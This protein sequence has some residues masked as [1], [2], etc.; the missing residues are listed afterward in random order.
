[1][2]RSRLAALGLTATLA[3]AAGASP[4]LAKTP[5]PRPSVSDI[6]FTH[7]IDKPS[8][9]LLGIAPSSSQSRGRYQLRLSDARGL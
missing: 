2:T 8:P 3:L 7:P 1:M 6:S 4:A 9:V 5:K